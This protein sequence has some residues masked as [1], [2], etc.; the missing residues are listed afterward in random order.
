MTAKKKL[1]KKSGGRKTNPPA[2]RAKPAAASTKSTGAGDADESSA[3]LRESA[4]SF[5]F[6]LLR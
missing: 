6:R 1:K 4:K 5:A 3:V 2:K